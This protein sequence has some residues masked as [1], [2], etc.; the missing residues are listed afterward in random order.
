MTD[1][2]RVLARPP[3]L[4]GKPSRPVQAIRVKPKADSLNAA[5]V[6]SLTTQVKQGRFADAV[7]SPA[8][9]VALLDAMNI[10]GGWRAEVD[11]N[12]WEYF[13][14]Y[15]EATLEG[16]IP[17]AVGEA[18]PRRK[19]AERLVRDLALTQPEVVHEVAQDYGKRV[20]ASI[21]E[22]LAV[23][24][25]FD[26]PTG[27]PT[28]PSSWKPSAF[29]RPRLKDGRDLPLLAVER[30][31]HMLAFSTLDRPYAGL[32]DVREACETRSLAE[33]AW[34]IAH[35]WDADGSQ[36]KDQWML[37][38]LAHLGDD[39][40]VRRTTPALTSPYVVHVLGRIG[41]NAAATELCTIAWRATQDA[42]KPRPSRTL[43]DVAAAFAAMA[44]KRG[45]TVDEIEDALLPTIPIAAANDADAPVSSRLVSLRARSLDAR[46]RLDYGTSFVLVGFD[47]RLDPFVESTGGR[48][49]RDLPHASP[50][51]DPALVAHAQEVWRELQEDVAAIADVRLASLERAMVGGRAWT[52]EAF[53]RA[54]TEH[55]L[56]RH[57]SRSVLWRSPTTAFR[58]AEDGTFADSRDVE[59]RDVDTV[60]VAHPAEIPSDERMR[61]SETFAD[62]RIIQP[63]EQLA[64]RVVPPEALGGASVTLAPA[65][66]TSQSDFYAR[67]SH[68][69]FTIKREGNEE[70]ATRSC[71]R[72]RKQLRLTVVFEQQM[73]KRLVLKL[74]KALSPVDIGEM[75]HDLEL[76]VASA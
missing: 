59:L 71:K 50:A 34:A 70:I 67:L 12:A 58:I 13:Q 72:G 1:L 56:M 5:G 68:K 48:K 10:F 51:D 37:E 31:G 69:G 35:T 25:R 43:A 52:L 44:R 3:W 30:V 54:W 27:P 62:Y 57:L 73:A 22:V 24:R 39:T 8:I 49:L 76:V 29:A 53:R 33:L 74:D 32:A 61:W 15:A 21:A 16:V 75:A 19:L 7:A 23:D 60:A 55:P 65:V 46:V 28:M 40:V 41:T 6:E 36:R 2:P 17:I 38:A 45:V 66:P 20:V 4:F 26:C 14:A 47:E 63:I 18:G 64:R 9:A 42:T 11:A